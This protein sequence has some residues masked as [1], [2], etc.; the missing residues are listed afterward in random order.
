MIASK[1][2]VAF[3]HTFPLSTGPGLPLAC[4][5]PVHAACVPVSSY[6]I[7]TAA[8]R[9]PCFL[10]ILRPLLLLQFFCLLFSGFLEPRRTG[11]NGNIL[12][13]GECCKVSHSRYIVWLWVPIF[14]PIYCG[15]KLL[16]WLLSKKLIYPWVQRMSLGAILLLHSFSRTV[17]FHFLLGSGLI[18]PQVLGWPN[19]V[20]VGLKPKR[21]V[22]GCSHRPCTTCTSVSCGGLTLVYW[23]FCGWL[24]F[25]FLLS[26]N[27]KY[28]P[29]LSTLVSRVKTM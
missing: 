17:V 29:G 25:I 13:R 14:V 24:W 28:L 5:G 18:S 27:A 12:L 21:I 1:L 22:V 3:M 20:G 11:L 26:Y 2:G 15:R 8:F 4:A 6:C 7:S 10:G 16:C 19:T 9:G 23:K